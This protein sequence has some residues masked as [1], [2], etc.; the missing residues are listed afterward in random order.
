MMSRCKGC[1]ARRSSQLIL[2]ITV[3][4]IASSAIAQ[5]GDRQVRS[6]MLVTTDWLASHLQDE[7][8]VVLCIVDDEQ[9]YTRGHIPK[10]RMIRLSQLVTTRG[11]VPNQLPSVDHLQQAFEAAG[12][13]NDS[14]IVL[15]G[16]RSGVTA[17]RAYF[18]LD[19]LG[20]GGGAALLD[21]GIE[22]WRAEGRPES[23]ASPR[24]AR[25]K[26]KIQPHPEILVGMQQM[27]EYARAKPG[28]SAPVL[29]DA[30]PREQYEGQRLSEDVSKAGHIPEAIGVYWR[31]TLIPRDIPQLRSPADL[32]RVF[33]LPPQSDKELVTY[34]RTGMQSSFD[35]FVLKY[36]GYNPQMYG[37]SFYEWS[38][39]PLPVESGARDSFR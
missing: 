38:R 39:S 15:Y 37:G 17:A 31:E 5:D 19:Y 25:T 32:R 33:A 8:L 30:R 29:I 22:K 1:L 36:L 4:V 34:C 16:E 13:E 14:R 24:V 3:A 7:N 21:G 9:F 10:S 6:E 26:L 27:A 23:T 28:P 11:G 2:G 12:V 35:Y 20:L 18:T